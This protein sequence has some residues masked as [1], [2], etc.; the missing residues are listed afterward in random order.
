MKVKPNAIPMGPRAE[1]AIELLGYLPVDVDVSLLSIV[2]VL[3]T[4]LDISL[5]EAR[6]LALKVQED[7]QVH[8]TVPEIRFRETEE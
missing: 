7:L 5:K 4:E 8:L 3:Y 2:K 6:D 1:K